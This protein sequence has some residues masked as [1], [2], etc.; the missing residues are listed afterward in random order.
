MS[1]ERSVSMRQVSCKGGESGD[2]DAEILAVDG[3]AGRSS[4]SDAIAKAEKYFAAESYREGQREALV[5]IVKALEAGYKY[6]VLEAPTGTGKSHIANAVAFSY[7]D[8]I[9]L[10][11]MKLLQDQYSQDFPRMYVMKGRGAYTC[12][13]EGGKYSCAE[14]P[15]RLDKT[16]SHGVLCP[17]R[18]AVEIAEES[19]VV[20]HNFDSFY[21]QSLHYNFGFRKLLVIDECHAMENKFLEFMKFKISNFRESFEIP[22]YDTVLEYIGFLTEFSEKLRV[23]I[24]ELESSQY[25][26]IAFVKRL[27]VLN[28]L[29]RK[30]DLFFLEF[31]KGTEYVF[32]RIDH[33]SHQA[34]E[35]QPVLVG[36]F[37]KNFLN[38]SADK[39]LM[40]SA[41]VLNVKVF[42]ET[43]GLDPEKVAF[44]RIP[45]SFPPEN[46]PIR[47][48]YS[49]SMAY[50]SFY[51]T[52]P[53]LVSDV[54]IIL[55]KF[56]GVRGI[57]HTHSEKILRELRDGLSDSRLT[58]QKDYDTY[59]EFMRVHMSKEDSVIV[60]SGLREGVDLR[61]DMS[62]FQILCKV[63]YP[64]LADVRVK[65]RAET[66][67]MWYLYQT[68]LMFVQSIGRSVRSKDDKAVT[69]IMDSGFVGFWNRGGKYFI[70]QYMKDAFVR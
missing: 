44:I 56:P 40:M 21:Y 28:S 13:E 19:P 51:D 5:Q 61:D 63:P 7:Y 54:K 57:I 15:C 17:F 43:V 48:T 34:L 32:E 58:F 42:C 52:V 70:P 64:S 14:G 25:Y 69:F 2:K 68:A 18:K 23:Q 9:I 50:K 38:R 67:S 22:V 10:T 45:S 36:T 31:E 33:G 55:D 66:S 1:G 26:D 49:G 3:T 39:V 65:R 16:I 24:S 20:L 12:V 29:R 53:K 35:F 60:A 62:R 4:E 8:T 11:L 41:T 6:V 37:I 46:R 59:E 27:E 47:F 30:L